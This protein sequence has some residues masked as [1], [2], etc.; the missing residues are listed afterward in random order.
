MS[1]LQNVFEN[2][3]VMTIGIKV[4]IFKYISQ[5]VHAEGCFYLLNWM[6]LG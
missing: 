1:K 3:F 6:L 2:K 4:F 5:P